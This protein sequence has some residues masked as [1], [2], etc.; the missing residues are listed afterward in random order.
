MRDEATIA[1]I[2]CPILLLTAK[3][4][5]MP[6]QDDPPGLVAF[7]YNGQQGAHQAIEG[8]GHAIFYDQFERFI[9]V[10]RDFIT[11][12]DGH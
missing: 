4:P 7:K 5:L 2:D 3:S 1:R 6:S 10:V 8:A 12:Q 9:A 11:I